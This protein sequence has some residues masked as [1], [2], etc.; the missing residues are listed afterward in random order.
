M[1]F[2]TLHGE[3]NR[4]YPRSNSYKIIKSGSEHQKWVKFEIE[5]FG[6][7]VLTGVQGFLS[8]EN[9]RNVLSGRF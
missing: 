3:K 8:R 2:F 6:P 5:L 9:V 4:Y 1:R 7:E